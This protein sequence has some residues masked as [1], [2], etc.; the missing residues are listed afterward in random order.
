MSARRS[1]VTLLELLAVCAILTLL[2]AL[3]LPAVQQARETARRSQC[4]NHLKQLG[5]ALHNYQ[6]VH[7]VFSPGSILGGWSWRTLLLPYIDQGPLYQSIRFENN[8]M[9]PPGAYS[10]NPEWSRLSAAKPGWDGTVPVLRC[11]NHPQMAPVFSPYRGV[12]GNEGLFG[13]FQPYFPGDPLQPPRNGMFF[14]CSKVQPGEVTDG[15]STT[16]LLGE[17]GNTASNFCGTDSGERDAWLSTLG[18]LRPGRFDDSVTSHYWSYHPHGAQFVFVD[19][20]VR[21]LSY[22]IDEQIFY[23]LG[24]RNGGEVVG[25]F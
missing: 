10:C 3:F 16:L 18:G 21:F 20:H 12:S 15:T 11:P 14:L 7:T 22:S 2:A 13:H 17:T 5:L 23:R 4:Q 25:D 1:G 8:I 6:S 24:S 19:G 9:Q